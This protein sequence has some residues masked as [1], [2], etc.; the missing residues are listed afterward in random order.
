MPALLLPLLQA[1]RPLLNKRDTYYIAA[2]L[3]LAL[4]LLGA[5]R[6]VKA[7]AAALAARPAIH[8][9]ADQ[10]VKT[11]RVA[12]PVRVETKTVYVPGTTQIQYVDRVVDTAPVTTTTEKE[13]QVERD[14]RPA[15]S[16]AAA[17][18]WRYLG[19]YTDSADA[20]KAGLRGGVTLWNTLDLGAGIV[21]SPRRAGRLEAAVRF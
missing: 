5:R 14:V 10:Q 18:P 19:L 1:L 15:C 3:V 13:S 11:V 21:F 8:M 17:L 12:G 20:S 16:A 4:L 9:E 2:I 7:D 6:T